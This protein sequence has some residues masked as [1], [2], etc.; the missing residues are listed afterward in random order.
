MT[1][2]G[3]L[4][5]HV[6]LAG[7]VTLIASSHDSWAPDVRNRECYRLDEVAVEAGCDAGVVV[8]LQR[9]EVPSREAGRQFTHCAL[10]VLGLSGAS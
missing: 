4:F 7:F 9:L 8:L 5:L 2:H 1:Y 6:L 3:A 10:T